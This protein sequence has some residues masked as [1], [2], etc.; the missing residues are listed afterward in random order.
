M[1][2]KVELSNGVTAYEDLNKSEDKIVVFL[3]G[4]TIP[5]WCYDHVFKELKSSKNR[6]IRYDMFGR[7]ESDAPCKTYDKAFYLKQFE[8]FLDALGVD[9]IDTLVGASFGASVGTLFSLKH[10]ARVKKIAYIS[11]A[12]N[13]M[14]NTSAAKIFSIPIFGKILF[15]TLGK[16][17]ITK[18]A[19]GFVDSLDKVSGD[20]YRALITKQFSKDSHGFWDSLYSQLITDALRSYHDEYKK[21]GKLNQHEVFLIWGVGDAEVS[22]DNVDDFK[23]YFK[24]IKITDVRGSGHGLM[25]EFPEKVSEFV[26]AVVEK[27]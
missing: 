3:H 14:A 5:S 9:K 22:Q 19:L 18:R 12:L 13:W 7:G 20:H 17:L 2:D 21:L 25:A 8:E 23:K 26:S 15:Y 10:P 16:K 27:I 6:L 11:P 24:D 1:M 4:G